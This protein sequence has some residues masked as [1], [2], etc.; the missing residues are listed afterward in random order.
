[1]LKIS[2]ANWIRKTAEEY[3]KRFAASVTDFARS[4]KEDFFV[5]A[6]VNVIAIHVAYGIFILCLVIGALYILYHNTVRGIIELLGTTL[7]S[8]TPAY[9]ATRI[10]SPL[11]DIRTQEI[12]GVTIIILL[13]TVFFGYLVARHALA[14]TKNALVAQKQFIGNIAHELRTPLAII[15]SNIEVRLLDPNVPEAGRRIH[16]S[17]LEELDRISDIINNLLSLNTLVNPEQIPFT[18]IDIGKVVNRVV[19]KLSHLAGHKPIRIRVKV[20]RERTA[21]GNAAAIE[22]IAINVIKNAIQHTRSGEIVITIGLDA[23]GS[24]AFVTRDTGS[25]IKREDLFRIF[26]PFY[27]G[28][29]ARTRTGGAGSGLGLSI[30]SELVKMHHGRVNIQSAPGHGTTVTVTLPPGRTQ[31]KLDGGNQTLNEVSAD[32]SHRA[33]KKKSR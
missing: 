6:E 24:L 23:Q 2:D 11:Q 33:R 5:R 17:N 28:D 27:R 15:K 12:T 7:A 21:W 10:L 32:F 13:S 4:Y 8:S 22:Q 26:E 1:M 3:W 20:A 9:T 14:P 18:T 16:V 29:S 31:T 30:V 19:E 25:G